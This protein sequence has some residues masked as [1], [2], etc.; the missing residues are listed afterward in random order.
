MPVNT[1]ILKFGG[2]SVADANSMKNVAEIIISKLIDNKQLSN[3]EKIDNKYSEKL[4]DKNNKNI[5][6]NYS[7]LENIKNKKFNKTLVVFLLATAKTTD[8][9]FKIMDL[10]IENNI[11]DALKLKDRLLQKHK[12]IIKDL[13]I[14]KIN[15][16]QNK[17]NELYKKLEI[18][19]KGIYYLGEIT[20]KAK[21]SILS[22]G[23]LS[24]TLIFSTYFIINFL[25]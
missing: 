18:L 15:E 16:L 2:T 4:N 7:K 24:S 20:P 8:T 11:E 19:I 12:K 17:L 23:E 21:D 5:N 14:D 9:L 22:I 1:I 13:N 3:K 6:I 10:A 25:K